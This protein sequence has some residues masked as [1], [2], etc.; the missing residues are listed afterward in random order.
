M[1]P[2]DLAAVAGEGG[3][4]WSA[5]PEGVH[6]NL[7]ALAADCSIGTHRNDALDVVVIV[8][9]GSGRA[10]VDGDEVALAP[11]LALVIPRGAERSFT[12]GPEGIRYLTVHAQRAPMG[13][14]G[15]R[16]GKD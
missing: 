16:V 8:L 3:V 7:I 13:I 2:V 5:S 4:V 11:T 12:A 9:A 1:E 14:G 15:R 6:V 10:L